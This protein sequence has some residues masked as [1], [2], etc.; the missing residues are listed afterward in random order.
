MKKILVPIDFTETSDNAFVHAIEM[1][2]V[3]HAELVL[4]HTFDLPII[5]NQ[6]FPENYIEVFNSAEL[7][8]FEY[9]KDKIRVLRE[10]ADNRKLGY[11]QMNHLLMDGDLIDAIKKAVK[12]E[13]IDMVVMGTNGASGWTSVFIGTNTGYVISDISVPVLSV[14]IE[15]KFQ[16]IETIAFTTRFREKDIEALIKVLKIAKKLHANVK[17]LYVKTSNSDVTDEKIKR[18]ESHFEDEPIQFF[19]IPSEDVKETIEDFLVNQ[20]ADIL[21]ILTYKRNF[22]AELFTHTLTQKLSYYLKTPILAFH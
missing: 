8:Q 11:I 7:A 18:W 4:L 5:D 16:K 15:A 2:K 13:N 6:L 1:A 19:V 14:P 9:F 21:A 10:L 22:F 17:C 12:Q 3:L 20:G